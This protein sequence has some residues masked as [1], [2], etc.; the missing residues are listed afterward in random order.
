M[1]AVRIDKGDKP[2]SYV[3][4]VE[5]MDWMPD[6]LIAM[7]STPGIIAMVHAADPAS[8]AKRAWEKALDDLPQVAG[9]IGDKR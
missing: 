1:Y 8:A 7:D 3:F 4:N 6:E 2:G 5:P 9:L